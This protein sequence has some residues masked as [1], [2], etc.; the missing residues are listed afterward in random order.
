MAAAAGLALLVLALTGS[1]P[2][3][4]DVTA[5]RAEGVAAGAAALTVCGGLWGVLPRLVRRS[6]PRAGAAAR[7][8]ADITPVAV[9]RGLSRA[10][11]RQW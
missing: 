11:R 7:G 6:G 8:V 2:L 9:R 5:G 1:V 10:P 3:V 4:V